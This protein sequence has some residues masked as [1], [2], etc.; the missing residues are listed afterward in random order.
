MSLND[1]ASLNVKQ[2]E[3]GWKKTISR[4]PLS[5]KCGDVVTKAMYIA[6]S[7]LQIMSPPH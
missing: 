3:V 4:A 7:T 1:V 5:Q 2:N 6:K